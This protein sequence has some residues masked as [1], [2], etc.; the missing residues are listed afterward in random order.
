MQH[1][2]LLIYPNGVQI[3]FVV[4]DDHTRFRIEIVDSVA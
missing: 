1:A 4:N 2:P 3:P